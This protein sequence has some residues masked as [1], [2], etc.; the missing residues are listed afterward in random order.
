MDTMKD[1]RKITRRRH[2][3]EIKA[4]VL[5]ECAQPGTS[6][7]SVALSYE[8]NAN[9]VHKWRRL[10]GAA[11]LPVAACFAPLCWACPGSASARL[12]SSRCWSKYCN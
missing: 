7:A 3:A 1:F 4:Q 8:I 2:S 12:A 6:V 10:A 9:I 5:S 11:A